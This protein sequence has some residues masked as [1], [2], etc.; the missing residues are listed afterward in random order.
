MKEQHV[1]NNYGIELCAQVL[2][3]LILKMRLCVYVVTIRKWHTDSK[4]QR[5]FL[6]NIV[7]FNTSTS[8]F[9]SFDIIFSLWKLS[10]QP[11][12]CFE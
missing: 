11:L 12:N 10:M 5:V 8:K 6:Q 2:R 7:T 3:S 9:Q 1:A 4:L